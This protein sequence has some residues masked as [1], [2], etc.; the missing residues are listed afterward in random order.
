M[1]MLASSNATPA[2][3]PSNQVI[4]LC[5]FTRAHISDHADDLRWN[6]R[7][8]DEQR[9]PERIFVA[10]NFLR[11][12]LADDNDVLPIGCVVFIEVAAGEK[13][14]APCL[15]VLWRDVVGGRGGAFIDRQDLAIGARVQ[16]VAARGGEERNV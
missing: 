2:K 4:G 1:P 9:F 7:T 15:E 14:N 6:A 11:A 13:R 10:E 3:I 8:A 12:A 5:D 16:E